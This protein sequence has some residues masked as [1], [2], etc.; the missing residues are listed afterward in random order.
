MLVETFGLNTRH[1]DCPFIWKWGGYGDGCNL[2]PG[3]LS[4]VKDKC[5][6]EKHGIITVK[7][8]GHKKGS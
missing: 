4:C 6:L 7:L 2:L 5:P 1:K 3:T 8:T